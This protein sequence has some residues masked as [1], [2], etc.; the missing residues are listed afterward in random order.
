MDFQIVILI[1]FN[2]FKI[3][4]QNWFLT[5][6]KY[7]SR[8]QAFIDLHWL[9]I[10]AH[11]D[12][13]KLMLVYNCLNKEAPKY[14]VNMLKWKNPTRNGLHSNNLYN[15]LEIPTDR[16][17]TF[18][19]RSFSYVGPTLWNELPDHLRTAHDTETFNKKLKPYLFKK[20]FA[21]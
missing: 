11:I 12:N 2:M 10:R 1:N 6:L 4:L 21:L 8:N 5:D 14:P 15:L 20:S 13:K 7:D 3:V 17:R 19:A 9:P 18:A 16:R